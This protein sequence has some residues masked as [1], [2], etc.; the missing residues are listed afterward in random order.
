MDRSE[1]KAYQYID[2]NQFDGTE[3]N[4]RLLMFAPKAKDLATWAGIPKKG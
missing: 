4:D 2:F 3:G 1:E